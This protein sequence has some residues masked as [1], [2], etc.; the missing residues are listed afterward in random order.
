MERFQVGQL[1]KE[2][3]IARLKQIDDPCEAAAEVLDKTLGIALKDARELDAGAREAVFSA[4]NGA[5]VGLLLCHQDLVRGAV[6]ALQRVKGVA[7]RGHL[8]PTEL[9]HLALRGIADLRRFADPE[10]MHKI[11]FAIDCEFMGAGQVFNELLRSPA[12]PRVGA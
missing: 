9:L 8:D 11:G 7:D 3:V 4:V 2:M 6:L 1:V 5:M 12:T 10:Q